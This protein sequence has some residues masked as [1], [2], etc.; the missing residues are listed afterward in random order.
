MGTEKITPDSWYTEICREGGSAL[1]LQIRSKI[2]DEQTPY[3]HLE[4]Y[5]TEKYGRLMTLDG[6][7]M[8]T[9][10]D[11]FIYHEMLVH[12]ALFTHPAP[13]KVLII[14][15]GDCGCLLETL[16]HPGV[17]RAELVEL[18]EQVTRAAEKYFPELCAS[19]NDPRA[20]LNFV[21]GIK[22]IAEAGAGSY[23][24]ILI[25]STDPVGPATGLFT[26]SFY[27]N[28][29]QALGPDGVLAAQS[30]SPLFHRD[31]IKDMRSAMDAAGFP[32]LA[33]LHFPQSTYPS[34]WWTV[35]LASK[36]VNPTDFRRTQTQ[37]SGVQTQYYS[38]ALHQGAMALP[39]F[40]RKHLGL[41]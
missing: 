34:G 17:E 14:G 18:D 22:W 31:I 37:D 10:R 9:G 3:Q 27:R 33:T 29:L 7:V 38:S 15:G 6:L 23:D 32:H 16:K 20:S 5:E 35:T 13:K 39:P 19:N 24:V 2:H 30:E 11:N 36:S 4:I 41:P 21:D 1:S 8:L 12:P 28:C 25:D 26:E 40:L